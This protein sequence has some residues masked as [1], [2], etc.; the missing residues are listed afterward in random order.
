MAS[1]GSGGMEEGASS[2]NPNVMDMLRRLN[3]T[4]EK[5]AVADFSDVEEDDEVAPVEW[6]LV[7]KVLSP[8]PVNV[9]TVRSAMKPT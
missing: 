9:N 3:L 7:G 2:Q 5:E 1:A 6:A 8:T 4:E